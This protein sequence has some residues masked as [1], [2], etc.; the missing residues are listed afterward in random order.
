[1]DTKQNRRVDSGS[2]RETARVL[3]AE[4]AV[5]GVVVGKVLGLAVEVVE[6]VP[7]LAP[8]PSPCPMHTLTQTSIHKSKYAQTIYKGTHSRMHLGTSSRTMP[9][10]VPHAPRYAGPDPAA[11][12]CVLQGCCVRNERSNGYGVT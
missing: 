2:E 3:R 12:A 6:T 10:A 9:V 5:L 7:P 1:M 8:C 11:D 4:V